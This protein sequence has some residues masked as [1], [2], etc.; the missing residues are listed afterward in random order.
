MKNLL[1]ERKPTT[2]SETEGFLSFEKEI[3]ATIE[4]PWIDD[5]TPGG[6]P[7]QSCIPDG[8]YDLVPHTRPDGKASLA[9]LG[10]AN[11]VYYAQGD[12]PPEGG[13]YLILIHVGNWV[14]DIVGCIAPGLAK[15][16][17]NQGPMVKSSSVAMKRILEYVDGD[18][19]Q[20]T[21]RWI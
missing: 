3:L 18:D 2:A 9:L 4:R 12:V 1:L 15:G 21:I 20:L 10:P 19:A 17:S 14:D 16:P 5:G 13:R 7:F 6:K 8:K 11:G